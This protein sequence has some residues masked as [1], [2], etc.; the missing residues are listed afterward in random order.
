MYTTLEWRRHWRAV[1]AQKLGLP[2]VLWSG[3]FGLGNVPHTE[4]IHV[5]TFDPFPTSTYTVDQVAQAHRDYLDYLQRCFESKK[6]ECG[7]GHKRLEFIGKSQPPI[8]AKL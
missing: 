3:P 1:Q 2:T 4:E 6:A 8:R 7:A 5:V